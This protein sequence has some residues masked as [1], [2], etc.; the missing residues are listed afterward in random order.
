MALC[1]LIMRSISSTM[2]D[3]YNCISGLILTDPDKLVE[4]LSKIKKK[5]KEVQKDEKKEDRLKGNGQHNEQSRST[6]K[7]TQKGKYK[8]EAA[9]PR[10]A[11]P[12]KKT[13]K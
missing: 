7:F 13:A 4:I 12:K 1:N 8:A 3:E 5:I 6:K 2:K 10:K 9:I 11:L